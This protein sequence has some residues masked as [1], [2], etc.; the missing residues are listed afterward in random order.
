MQDYAEEPIVIFDVAADLAVS[1]RTLQAAFRQWRDTTR[2]LF[3]R[4]MRLHRVREGLLAGK[5]AVTDIA[6]RFGFSHLG[7]FSAY[8]EAKF[9]ER[10][11][12]TLQRPRRSR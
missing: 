12:V 7:R 8:Y 6:L 1:V 3:L 9:G 10:P 2:Q 11:S 5:T 4:D